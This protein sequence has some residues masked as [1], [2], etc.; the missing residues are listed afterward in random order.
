MMCIRSGKISIW[1][2]K[3]MLG[4]SY[5]RLQVEE[6]ADAEKDLEPLLEN[7][8]L[9]VANFLLKGPKLVCI[10]TIINGY[11]DF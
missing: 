3:K 6:A 5:R 7:D 9:F 11:Q 4:S 10:H 2:R 1:D 8:R